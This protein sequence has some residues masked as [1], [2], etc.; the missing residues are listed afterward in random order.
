MAT[1]LSSNSQCLC[2][3]KQYFLNA[4][5]LKSVAKAMLC[6]C[7]SRPRA[8]TQPSVFV[9]CHNVVIRRE[10]IHKGVPPGKAHS[11]MKNRGRGNVPVPR[12]GGRSFPDEASLLCALQKGWNAAP[13]APFSQR[14][15]ARR[16]GGP[17]KRCKTINLRRSTGA[18][19][20]RRS[21]S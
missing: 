21:A 12:R 20:R 10:L 5:P 4:I 3:L 2:G 15:V 18:W 16:S 13:F 14:G 19:R 9:R 8:N 17:R 6:L 7:R 11:C 1:R